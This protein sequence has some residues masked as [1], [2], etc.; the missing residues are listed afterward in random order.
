MKK[1]RRGF[2]ACIGL[3]C[4]A[5]IVFFLNRPTKSDLPFII[6]GII[7]IILGIIGIR[8]TLDFEATERLETA[9]K[10]TA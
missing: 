8:L 10:E 1:I 7:F 9:Q 5:L 6:G 2:Y 4:I 3:D